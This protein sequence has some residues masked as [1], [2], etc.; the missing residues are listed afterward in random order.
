[1]Q[2]ED[3]QT[4]L[5]KLLAGDSITWNQFTFDVKQAPALTHL[6]AEDKSKAKNLLAAGADWACGGW[7]T[8]VASRRLWESIRVPLVSTDPKDYLH[9]WL[10]ALSMVWQV[11]VPEMALSDRASEA[12]FMFMEAI[13]GQQPTPAAEAQPSMQLVPEE[14]MRLDWEEEVEP[15]SKE[16]LY[17]WSK[18][19]QGDRLPLKEVLENIPRL[20]ELP[21]K[22][23]ENNHRTT[24]ADR[25]WRAIQQNMLHALRI[26]AFCYS[27]LQESGDPALSQELF[28]KGWRQLADSYFRAEDQRKELAIPGS[29]A[30]NQ[31]HLFDKQDLNQAVLAQ[32]I[33]FFRGRPRYASTPPSQLKTFR[34]FRPFRSFSPG[35][36]KGRSFKGFKGWNTSASGYGSRG[37]FGYGSHSGPKA[38]KSNG[39]PLARPARTDRAPANPHPTF[40][41]VESKSALVGEAWRLTRSAT[42][43]QVW[44][45]GRLD[46]SQHPVLPQPA[47]AASGRSPGLGSAA[48]IRRSRSCEASLPRP[49]CPS[50]AMVCDYKAFRS[51]SENSSHL[52]LSGTQPVHATQAFQAGSLATHFS[53][54][55]PGYVGSQDRPK[56]CLFSFGPQQ[57]TQALCENTSSE[58]AMGIPSSML[59]SVH[60]PL[61]LDSNHE[62]FTSPLAWKRHPLL[63]VSGRHTPAWIFPKACFQE[64]GFHVAHPD[65]K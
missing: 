11:D 56:E 16:L 64:L 38:G 62:G 49:N 61:P 55:P 27:N 29:T 53:K 36:G 48:G 59:R 13:T 28:Q 20:Q 1:M 19:K 33:R 4:Y 21:A 44:S 9:A 17:L 15:L 22:A 60:P 57:C 40:S 12:A 30:T 34:S 18:A 51:R 24:T 31:D 52:R 2:A 41:Q 7:N 45:P 14:D 39:I 3:L 46:P 25:H 58:S 32:K 54:P 50:G 65:W 47:Q 10:F 5:Q 6:V 42:S 63:C 8:S 43:H 26:F 23:P 35:K 37:R